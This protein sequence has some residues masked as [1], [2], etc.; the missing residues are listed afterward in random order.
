MIIITIV[1]I[2]FIIISIVVILVT[3]K[4]NGVIIILIIVIRSS[5]H[6]YQSLLKPSPSMIGAMTKTMTMGKI[7]VFG[8][9]SYLPVFR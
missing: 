7:K 2:I 5:S 1:T 4:I 6:D 8:F 9:S 3:V